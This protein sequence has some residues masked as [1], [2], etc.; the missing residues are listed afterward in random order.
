MYPYITIRGIKLY[1]TGIGIVISFL[2]FVTIVWYLSRRYLQSFWKFF[3]WLPVLISLAYFLGSYSQFLLSTQHI[4]PMSWTDLLYILAPYDYKFNF[5]GVLLGILIALFI[6]FKNI[7][8]IEN[9]KIW[10]DI[11][12]FAFSLSL[13]PFGVFLLLG[14]NF[15]GNSTSSFLGVKSLHSES[16]WNKFDAVLPIGLFLSLGSLIV[17]LWIHIR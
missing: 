7:K 6:F 15:I 17:A 9:K 12:F 13:I 10:I 1:M 3:Y 8:T 11:F 2:T 4:L 5:A 16:Q 14:D